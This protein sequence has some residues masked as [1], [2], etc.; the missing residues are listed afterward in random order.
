MI[1]QEWLARNAV[2][3][4][5]FAENL[6]VSR[7]SVGR[8]VR[9]ARVPHPRL[10]L[11]IQEHTRGHVPATI[12]A[13]TDRLPRGS[14]ALVRWMWER[15]LTP[16]AAARGMGVNHTSV[17]YWARGMAVPSPASL[18]TINDFTGLDL[19]EGDFR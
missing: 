11:R 10:A 6:G 1:L 13:D 12:W 14:A 4:S 3:Y 18:R 7:A 2:S 16:S 8:W 9:G 5:S 17:G 19:T 15:G